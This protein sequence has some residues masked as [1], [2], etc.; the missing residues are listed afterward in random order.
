MNAFKMFIFYFGII[1]KIL[2]IVIQIN[3]GNLT[4]KFLSAIKPSN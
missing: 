1:Y 2:D 4:G 3:T